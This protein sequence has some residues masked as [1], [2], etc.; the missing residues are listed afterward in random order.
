MPDHTQNFSNLL[1]DFR[2]IVENDEGK[3][4]GNKLRALTGAERRLLHTVLIHVHRARLSPRVIPGPSQFV[5]LFL[6]G[7]HG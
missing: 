2:N 4:F 6:P 1:G 5:A 3:I 7:N